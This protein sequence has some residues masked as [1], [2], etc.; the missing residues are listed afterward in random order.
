M[1]RQ[2]AH[3]PVQK[4][5]FIY[6]SIFLGSCANLSRGSNPTYLSFF[7]STAWDAYERVAAGVDGWQAPLNDW[8]VTMAV[9]ERG[10]TAF[11]SRLAAAGW[12][13]VFSDGDGAL[14]VAPGR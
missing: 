8:G 13:T 14:F 4:A 2:S 10:D 5:T 12:H 1:P 3:F 9:V 11:G 7:P 6:H